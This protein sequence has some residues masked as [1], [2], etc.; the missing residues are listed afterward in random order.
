MHDHMLA[1]QTLLDSV[2]IYRAVLSVL[3]HNFVHRTGRIGHPLR[4]GAQLGNIPLKNVALLDAPKP[5]DSFYCP[6]SARNTHSRSWLGHRPSETLATFS[7][8]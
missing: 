1:D 2:R 8:Q 7:S 6:I 5:C 4:S 3:G